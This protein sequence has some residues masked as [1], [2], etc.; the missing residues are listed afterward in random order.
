MDESSVG[1][2]SPKI[3]VKTAA[4]SRGNNEATSQGNERSN[5]KGA[6]VSVSSKQVRKKVTDKVSCLSLLKTSSKSTGLGGTKLGGAVYVVQDGMLVQLP[7]ASSE[8][9]NN[10]EKSIPIRILKGSK[11]ESTLQISPGKQ[12]NSSQ[13]G[14]SP[15][16]R[17]AIYTP[18]NVKTVS[19]GGKTDKDSSRLEFIVYE[20]DGSN[21]GEGD[22]AAG[23]RL[24][25]DN[26][27]GPKRK[28]IKISNSS[29][30][31]TSKVVTVKSR[32]SVGKDL[33]NRGNRICKIKVE[34]PQSN[35][36]F[37]Q[38][39][40]EELPAVVS[41]DS[42]IC[43]TE[44][45]EERWREL[46][47]EADETAVFGPKSILI[48]VQ[49]GLSVGNSGEENSL[50][51]GHAHQSHKGSNSVSANV[52]RKSQILRK[53][54]PGKGVFFQCENCGYSSKYKNSVRRHKE[55]CGLENS[56]A[57]RSCIFPNCQVKFYHVSQMIRHME[58]M[59]SACIGVKNLKF[60]S[61]EEFHVWKEKEEIT[62]FTYFTKH[63][64]DCQTKN[65][66]YSIYICQNDGSNKSHRRKD[67]PPRLTGRRYKKGTI[68]T[69]STCP[70]RM[71]VTT[72]QGEVT[73]KYFY[74][75]NHE[76]KFEN[77]QFHPIARKSLDY[78]KS[79]FSVGASP[80]QVQEELRNKA[81]HREM[82]A[83]DEV[84]KGQLIS[85]RTLNAIK[86]EYL[87][88]FRL[89]KE[90]ANS[91]F[92]LVKEWEK[93]EFNPIMLYKPQYCPIVIGNCNKY[94]PSKS[95][96]FFIALQ[97]EAQLVLLNSSTNGFLCIDTTYFNG[98]HSF[99]LLSLIIRDGNGTGIPVAHFISNC[100]TEEVIRYFFYSIKERCPNLSFQ[101]VM[102][103]A[104]FS[105]WEAFLAIFGYVS[106]HVVCQWH[107]K[108]SWKKK[109]ES[110]V[111]SDSQKEVVNDL[112]A[113]MQ[114]REEHNLSKLIVNF[115]LKYENFLPK[116]VEYF[117]SNIASQPELWAMCFRDL[118]SYN[119]ITDMYCKGFHDTLEVFFTKTKAKKRIDDLLF[120]LLRIEETDTEQR[121]A[122][123]EA[124]HSA[125]NDISQLGN[126]AKSLEIADGDVS[127][128]EGR[129]KVVCQEDR[130]R[131]FQVTK[132]RDECPEEFCS[133]ECQD[134]P[135][136]NL[137]SHMYN[138]SCGDDSGL[139]EHVHK[140]HSGKSNVIIICSLGSH[141]V[142]VHGGK[143]DA[144]L[145]DDP[146]E[147]RIKQEKSLLNAAY[148]NLSQ[149][150][151]YISQPC[152][153]DELLPQIVETLGQL[154]MKCREISQNVDDP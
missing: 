148:D 50:D 96:I 64:G 122:Q 110:L 65:G 31:V 129:W 99:Y 125:A 3:I 61:V 118:S 60:T 105:G 20:N 57:K 5:G 6:V 97:T 151:S 36:A 111:E 22:R 73:V 4:S 48:T 92:L 133:A 143:K 149:L 140:V 10:R 16:K 113:M 141:S 18:A 150:N 69:G 81:I 66:L 40:N 107:I 144:V 12:P 23:K 134:L 114:E 46:E 68:K 7:S 137:C 87:S 131:S 72:Y 9:S 42:R 62:N 21:V 145:Y 116:F 71:F 124:S 102:T 80:K 63:R 123:E 93:K 24:S 91:V 25:V 139:C 34:P 100:R 33:E 128:S 32:P 106:V 142:V 39:G 90:D 78:I 135:C 17:T 82:K 44:P 88:S 104:D 29:D 101:G 56:G 77:T 146:S 130:S 59:H 45:N 154:V 26:R 136:G 58:V 127:E 52:P 121:L 13:G 152:V 15:G 103:D 126:H 84:V 138:C 1:T 30:A 70:S 14:S 85:L 89:D 43:K 54:D 95:D 8:S 76:L 41:I 74:S 86:H 147:T 38:P 28:R 119:T 83:E 53:V 132:L 47:G 153:Q 98:R 49:D 37:N 115:K 27:Q 94:F 35:E 11:A 67:E 75:H 2:S 79:R 51:K 120:L 108:R 19:V 112:T 117:Q 55:H 109:V